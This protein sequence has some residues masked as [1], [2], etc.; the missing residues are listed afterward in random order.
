MTDS[1]QPLCRSHIGRS[2]GLVVYLD[3]VVR[4]Q[5]GSKA[6]DSSQKEHSKVVKEAALGLLALLEDDQTRLEARLCTCQFFEG[7]ILE[8][9]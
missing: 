3:I 4:Q 6:P 8:G 2:H 9:V 7:L 1:C 5:E